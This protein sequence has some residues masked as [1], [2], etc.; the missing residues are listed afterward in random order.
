MIFFRYHDDESQVSSAN[1]GPLN[2]KWESDVT[3]RLLPYFSAEISYSECFSMTV[4][5]FVP[6]YYTVDAFTQRFVKRDCLIRI[7]R[8]FAYDKDVNEIWVEDCSCFRTQPCFT[9][10]TSS[11]SA[12]W[13]LW[14][15]T[16]TAALS[17]FYC[18]TTYFSQSGVFLGFVDFDVYTA[19]HFS[20]CSSQCERPS[21][22]NVVLFVY[23]NYNFLSGTCFWLDG[24]QSLTFI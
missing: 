14:F 8:I 2:A 13:Y 3:A 1:L 9:R 19:M 4:D 6:V 24:L 20:T 7:K 23:K 18:R 16:R 5:V 11:R 22:I 17:S 21:F 15:W 10:K 12:L